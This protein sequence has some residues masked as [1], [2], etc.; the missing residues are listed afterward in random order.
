MS[1]FKKYGLTTDEYYKLMNKTG[2]TCYICGVP[3]KKKSLCIDHD[4]RLAKKIGIRSSVRG[5]LCSQCNRYLIGK[6]GDKDNAVELFLKAA[7]YL[8]LAKKN[9]G[10][11]D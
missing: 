10:R 7:E 9:F 2:N 5:L 6:M 1:N 8:R 11:L 3:P 4:H